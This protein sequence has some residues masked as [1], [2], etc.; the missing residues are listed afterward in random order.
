MTCIVDNLERVFE[1]SKTGAS[2]IMEN[3]HVYKILDCPHWNDHLHKLVIRE[4]PSAQIR[5]QASEQS[6]SGFIITLHIASLSERIIWY[7]LTTPLFII[8]SGLLHECWIPYV[9]LLP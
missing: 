4:Y 2:V 1:S 6:L 9:S 7:V 5:I 8:L 3:H